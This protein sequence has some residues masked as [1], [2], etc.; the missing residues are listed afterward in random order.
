MVDASKRASGMTAQIAIFQ[1]LLMIVFTKLYGHSNP[2]WIRK[3]YAFNS[4][5]LLDLFLCG[6][7]WKNYAKNRNAAMLFY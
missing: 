6:A 7:H 1:I 2:N 3:S 4:I 5:F